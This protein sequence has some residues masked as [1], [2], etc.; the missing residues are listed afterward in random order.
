MRTAIA[1]LF[2][3]LAVALIPLVAAPAAFA[4][5]PAKAQPFGVPASQGA[6]DPSA[7][8]PSAQPTAQTSPGVMTRAWFWLLGEQSRMNREMAAAVKDLKSGDPVRAAGVLVLIA[9]L[10]GVLHAAG[11]GH[12]KA[13]ISSYVLSNEE[14]VRRG[15]ALSFLS[16]LFQA[17]SAIVFVGVFAVAFNKT[18]LEMRASEALLETLSWGFVALVGAWMLVRQARAVWPRHAAAPAHDHQLHHD[19]AHDHHG[20]DCG[21]GHS[22]MPTP[23]QLQGAWSWRKALPLAL[24][25]G[26]RP[27]TG[28]LFLLI[29]A[30]SQG[31]WWA[32]VLGTFAMALGTALTVSVLATLAVSSRDLAERLSGEGGVWAARIH[33]AAGF[34]GA[35]LVFLLGSAFFYESLKGGGPL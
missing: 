21:C 16:A 8:Q 6:K 33:T 34:A 27:C 9:F 25:V 35:G 10:Y 5:P 32:G 2:A 18:S 31:M 17:L 19:H 15:I 3:A 24:S 29:F 14:T 4:E 30:M 28:A 26:I 13:V 1:A 7:A 12:G 11:P 23:D 20:P 22:H